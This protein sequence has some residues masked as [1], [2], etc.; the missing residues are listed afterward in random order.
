MTRTGEDALDAA[1]EQLSVDSGGLFESEAGFRASVISIIASWVV[2]NVFLRPVALI[3]GVVDWVVAS[4]TSGLETL[5]K[6]SLGA[7][8]ASVRESILGPGGVIPSVR[9]PLVDV[10]TSAGLAAPLAVGVSNVVIVGVVVGALFLL[11]RAV[12]GYLTGGV[13]A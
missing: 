10:A 1:D 3:L 2:V 5:V 6:T 11:A 12:A 7:V 9:A 13:A 4:L 8:G